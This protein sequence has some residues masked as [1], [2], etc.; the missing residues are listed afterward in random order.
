MLAVLRPAGAPALAGRVIQP[1]G[2]RLAGG[3]TDHPECHPGVVLAVVA[4]ALV[5]SALRFA[6]SRPVSSATQGL[7]VSPMIAICV[8]VTAYVYTILS[9]VPPSWVKGKRCLIAVRKATCAQRITSLAAL[10]LATSLIPESAISDSNLPQATASY[11]FA[12]KRGQDMQFPKPCRRGDDDVPRI[13]V[14]R[15][16]SAGRDKCDLGWLIYDRCGY[17]GVWF[18]IPVVEMVDAHD[19]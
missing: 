19:Q 14:S 9:M 3:P 16:I 11:V 2:V 12:C 4:V 18:V 6:V 10:S 5:T 17:G 8:S 15:D 7:S 1:G 13:E